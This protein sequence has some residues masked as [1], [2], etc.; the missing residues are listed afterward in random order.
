MYPINI[1]SELIHVQVAKPATG[2]YLT[3]FSD[4]YVHDHIPGKLS[5]PI[6]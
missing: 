4:K 5:R 6:L 1:K 2:Y 3:L